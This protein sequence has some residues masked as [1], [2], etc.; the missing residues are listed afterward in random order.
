MCNFFFCV[1]E[2]TVT[3]K[4]DC[5]S[6]KDK[7]L[8]YFQRV[9]FITYNTF[10]V[11]HNYCIQFAFTTI[12]CRLTLWTNYIYVCVFISFKTFECNLQNFENLHLGGH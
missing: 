5:Q 11:V 6:M 10:T 3:V 1:L 9:Y 7:Q 4:F 8:N 2:M 12:I